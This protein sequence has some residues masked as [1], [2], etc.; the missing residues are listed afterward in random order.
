MSN[1][2]EATR[3]ADRSGVAELD[4]EIA[5]ILLRERWYSEA[6]RYL[7]RLQRYYERVRADDTNYLRITT[8]RALTKLYQG[9]V[10]VELSLEE[11]QALLQKA[12]M[13]KDTDLAIRLL[14]ALGMVAS[15][16]QLVELGIQVANELVERAGA[17]ND[18]RVAVGAFSV[19]VLLLAHF[20]SV[21]F[22]TKLLA[23]LDEFEASKG[24]PFVRGAIA[25]C[26]AQ[27]LQQA[28]DLRSADEQYAVVALIADKFALGPTWLSA[29]NNMAV[30]EMERGRYEAAIRRLVEVEQYGLARE[31]KEILQS[32]YHNLAICHWETG[33]Y[34]ECAR[35]AKQLRSIQ[36]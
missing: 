9:T 23:R 35:A 31:E 20:D 17:V 7:E 16:A 8:E 13:K 32:V 18:G 1:D 22:A 15:E 27:V 21:S 2:E 30:V 10:P 24:S 12:R 19:G 14:R 26:Q 25:R 34:T 11:L 4:E 6:D 3:R 29:G 36:E 33:E 5:R 28:G